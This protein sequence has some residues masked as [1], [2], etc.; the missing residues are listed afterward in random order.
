MLNSTA[1]YVVTLPERLAGELKALDDTYAARL[2]G[3]LD[4]VTRG[5]AEAEQRGIPVTQELLLLLLDR[6]AHVLRGS[7]EITL[8]TQVTRERALG[9]GVEADLRIS[10]VDVGLSFGYREGF[11]THEAATSRLSFDWAFGN[12]QEH[13]AELLVHGGLDVQAARDLFLAL[14]GAPEAPGVPEP[15]T[16]G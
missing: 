12:I 5:L 8:A 15:G 14:L 1:S 10:V 6:S 7:R 2:N 3:M 13:L 9:G 11:R 16:G 4:F